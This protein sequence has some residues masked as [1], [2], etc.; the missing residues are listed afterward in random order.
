MARRYSQ[1]LPKAGLSA[2]ARLF[3]NASWVARLIA[4]LLVSVSLAQRQRSQSLAVDK[5]PQSL[6]RHLV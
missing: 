5:R 2:N 4:C 1:A 6:N 3:A